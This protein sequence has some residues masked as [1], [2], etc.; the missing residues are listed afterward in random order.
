M[1]FRKQ[2]SLKEI[3]D[4]ILALKGA[5]LFSNEIIIDICCADT[6][7]RVTK[8]D[9]EYAIK[10]GVYMLSCVSAVNIFGVIKNETLRKEVLR[11]FFESLMDFNSAQ[12]FGF[13]Q[14][15]Y[16]IFTLM[17][18]TMFNRC[19]VKCSGDALEFFADNCA[20]FISSDLQMSYSSEQIKF[21]SKI[22]HTSNKNI[23]GEVVAES[24]NL[25]L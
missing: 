11:Y 3:K 18:Q 20:N 10:L 9:Y 12:E 7:Y 14:A 15:N 23:Y 24:M 13:E 5:I 4:A 22:I 6:Q 8:K 19:N 17:Y 25:N 21:L 16:H 1:F 2:K